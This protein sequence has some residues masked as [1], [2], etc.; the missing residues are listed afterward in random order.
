MATITKGNYMSSEECV[1]AV[2]ESVPVV[3]MAIRAEMRRNRAADLSIPHFRALMFLRRHA[4]ACLSEVA[5]HTGQSRPSASKVMDG[6]VN[7][8]FAHRRVGTTDRRHVALRL[9]RRGR[10]V[11]DRTWQLARPRLAERL[12]M[13][14]E[15]KRND[16][17]R[18]LLL[19]K[20]VFL[21]GH[22]RMENA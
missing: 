11:L 20:E 21:A 4:D 16:L 2:M 1:D 14:P 15:N 6:L 10:A 13:V 19:L 5:D 18:S 22:E 9:T 8:G 12:A 3:M 7:R 17:V